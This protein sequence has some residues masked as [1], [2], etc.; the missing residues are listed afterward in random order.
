M[1]TARIRLRRKNELGAVI[2]EGV[3]EDNEQAEKLLDSVL[4]Q[5]L[6]IETTVDAEEQGGD[7][8]MA[9]WLENSR[10][11]IEDLKAALADE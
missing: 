9:S 10:F 5:L 4:A 8:F 11:D 6:Q 3:P 1:M 2:Q 7:P